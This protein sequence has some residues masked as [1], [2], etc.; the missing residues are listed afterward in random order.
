MTARKKNAR[1]MSKGCGHQWPSNKRANA[2]NR[3]IILAAKAQPCADCGGLFHPVCMDFDHRD[4]STKSFAIGGTMT[5]S[6]SSVRAELAKCDVVCAN[7]HRLR[8]H[9][10]SGG[11]AMYLHT[12]TASS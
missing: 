12:V 3:E 6:E 10:P 11:E 1:E 4:P 5:R 9:A 8:H 2:R 7:C